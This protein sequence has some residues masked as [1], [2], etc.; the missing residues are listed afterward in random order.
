MLVQGAWVFEHCGSK[1][2]CLFA[3]NRMIVRNYCLFEDFMCGATG[4]TPTTSINISLNLKKRGSSELVSVGHEAN[5]HAPAED[6][7][8]DNEPRAIG[9]N[10]CTAI[11]EFE[12]SLKAI[13]DNNWLAKGVQI[14]DMF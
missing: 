12:G 5:E 8:S 11:E 6:V 14:H 9:V 10:F 1:E 7:S 2:N 4:A 3:K 13:Y